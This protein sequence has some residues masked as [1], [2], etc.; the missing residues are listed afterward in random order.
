[1]G[2]MCGTRVEEKYMWPNCNAHYDLITLY[3]DF[4]S[5]VWTSL[6]DPHGPVHV[7]LGGVVDCDK[8]FDKIADLTNREISREI[9]YFSFVYRKNLWRAGYFKCE[10]TA[11]VEE[12]PG[13]VGFLAS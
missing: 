13:T 11:S 4:Y 6:Y 10:G 12:T 1:M 8:T 9:S 2:G 5:Y 7:W 3:D